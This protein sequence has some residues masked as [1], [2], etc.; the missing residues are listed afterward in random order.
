[1]WEDDEFIYFKSY[2]QIDMKMSLPET[3]FNFIIP[4]RLTSY[5]KGLEDQMKKLVASNSNEEQK[6]LNI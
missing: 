6:V 2:A 1:M 4:F 5:Y 3:F